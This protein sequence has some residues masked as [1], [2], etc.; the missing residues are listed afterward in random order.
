MKMPGQIAG[1]FHFC[2]CYSERVDTAA[3]TRSLLSAGSGQRTGAKCGILRARGA[4]TAL[5]DSRGLRP[6]RGAAANLA[7]ISALAAY[8]YADADT[9][10]PTTAATGCTGI[11]AGAHAHAGGSAADG[12]TAVGLG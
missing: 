2:A 12:G 11:H 10:T 8:A 1:H 3:G 4:A 7:R 5:R 6:N 9:R